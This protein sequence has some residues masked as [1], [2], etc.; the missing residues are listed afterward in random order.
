MCYF[1]MTIWVVCNTIGFIDQN[2]GGNVKMF[3]L[4]LTGYLTVQWIEI[5]F[6]QAFLIGLTNMAASG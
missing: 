3:M 4:G 6:K 5:D 1:G 2:N